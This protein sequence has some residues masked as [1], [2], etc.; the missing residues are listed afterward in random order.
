MFRYLILIVA[1]WLGVLIVRQFVRR[2]R[3]QPPP[4][5]GTVEQMVQCAHC[6]VH[7]PRCEAIEARGNYYCCEQHSRE[8]GLQ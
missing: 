5:T 7:L 1:I 4:R 6:G 3:M 8:P 2:S